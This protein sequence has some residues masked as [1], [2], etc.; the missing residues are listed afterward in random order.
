MRIDP[1]TALGRAVSRAE[2]ARDA[3]TADAAYHEAVGLADGVMADALAHDHVA[4]LVGM[5]AYPMALARCSEYL[6]Q[7]PDDPVMLLTR[8]EIHG[9]LTD[10]AAA[11]QDAIAIRPTH[12]AENTARLHRIFGQIA[13]HRGD[14]EVAEGRFRKARALFQSAGHI[15]GVAT[16]DDDLRLLG[17]QRGD[18][19]AV[20][21]TIEAWSHGSAA[22][23]LAL[24]RALKKHL[25]YEAALE[26]LEG[27]HDS[28]PA[29]DLPLRA[30]Q[31]ELRR[32]ARHEE[33]AAWL[34]QATMDADSPQ[35]TRRLNQVQAL[36]ARGRILLAHG[37][38]AESAVRV[39]NAE[40]LLEQLRPL[41]TTKAEQAS[42]HLVAGELELGHAELVERVAPGEGGS[43]AYEAIGHLGR[44][45]EQASATAMA[46]VRILAL[47]LLGHAYVL[48]DA[49]WRAVTCWR[50]ADRIEKDIVAIQRTDDFKVRMSLAGRD[51]HDEWVQVASAAIARSGRPAAAGVAVAIEA[52]R[53][54]TI[55]DLLA[56]RTELPPPGDVAGAGRW[57]RDS[58]RDLPRSQV[59]WLMYAAPDQTHHVLLGRDFLQYHAT[60]PEGSHRIRLVAAIEKLMGYWNRG[61]LERSIAGGDFDK[62]LTEIAAKIDIVGVL[63][64]LPREVDRIAVVAHGS[65]AYIPFAAL[66]LAG[67]ADRVVHRFAMSELPSLSARRPL[68]FRARRRLGE[69][70]V[71]LDPEGPDRTR[72]PHARRA[73]L[74]GR[75]ATPD[76]LR[77][78]AAGRN[79]VRLDSHG[80]YTAE[81][82]WLQLAPEGP[83][84]LLRA[85]DLGSMPLHACGTAILG[86]CES[87]MTRAVG[88][89]EHVGFARSAIRAG[90]SAVVA[91]RWIAE[92]PIAGV[93]LDLFEHYLTY[94]PRDRA[95]H[96][97]QLDICSGQALGVDSPDHP[98]RWACW[99]V[100][101]D[102]GWQTN[103]GPMRRW[104]RAKRDNRRNIAEKAHTSDGVPV[105]RRQ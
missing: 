16:I 23:R 78:L 51:E 71:V 53:G 11:E 8:A 67:A 1:R 85:A 29:L 2:S 45:A 46:E 6:A 84:G 37:S 95:L 25:R 63:W 56:G 43:V 61:S 90:A 12:G 69:R 99:T 74:G 59:V 92:E 48:V 28:E 36:L 54:A 104:L 72:D 38:L 39:A 32:L 89:D 100:H 77:S 101:G 49:G 97:A 65:L 82:A 34:V 42:W 75:R 33:G 22:E 40:Q 102:A 35:F 50:A 4:S 30:E 21:E 80:R 73:V 41:A 64:D 15:G 18:E 13:A 55:T 105:V 91:A 5:H 58:T 24:A 62:A 94:L 17:V 98:A 81:D 31:A 60:R 93:L 26:V 3:P 83:D 79:I 27:A 68:G 76:S 9:V 86:A 19:R 88:K 52:A 47:R 7:L 66:P 70:A 103:A 96:Q 10:Y 87:G 57:V 14:Y 20:V 44:A